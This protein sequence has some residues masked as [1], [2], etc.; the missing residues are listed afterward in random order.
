M[1]FNPFEHM[2]ESVF[3]N[4]PGGPPFQEPPRETVTL[5]DGQIVP[6]AVPGDASSLSLY[7]MS[8]GHM[9]QATNDQGF[10]QELWLHFAYGA[11]VSAWLTTMYN[12]LGISPEPGYH[13]TDAALKAAVYSM[14]T[15]LATLDAAGYTE[16]QVLDYAH[17][18]A[19]NV[20]IV[21]QP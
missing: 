10:A 15:L 2:D 19:P 3:D 17:A 8:N 13:L 9:H 20:M 18:E 16:Q 21:G 14:P 11:D 12:G 4:L 7:L 6:A 5:F 1:A